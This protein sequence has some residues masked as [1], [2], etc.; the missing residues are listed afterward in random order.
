MKS[1][2]VTVF[3]FLFV[4]GA[5]TSV[6][7]LGKAMNHS[8]LATG[9]VTEEQFLAGR[10]TNATT[11]WVLV[12]FTVLAGV[13]VTFVYVAQKAK[14][15]EQE[16]AP[17]QF[18]QVIQEVKQEQKQGEQ[19]ALLSL[20]TLAAVTQPTQQSPILT[21]DEIRQRKAFEEE[22]EHSELFKEV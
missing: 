19:E 7:L 3:A 22:G 10:E 12:I 20:R 14:Q 16:L 18:Q 21:E 5:V 9:K 13:A 2:L 1:V 4:V 17:T 15:P 11:P 8:N 6:F